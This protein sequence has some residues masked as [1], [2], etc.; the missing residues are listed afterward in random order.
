MLLPLKYSSGTPGFM[1]C[2]YGELCN[3]ESVKRRSEMKKKKKK[4]KK[5]KIAVVC[6]LSLSLFL[7]LLSPTSAD[8]L[9]SA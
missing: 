8:R 7:L 6:R 1:S 2:F 9:L 5:K 4:K 3:I